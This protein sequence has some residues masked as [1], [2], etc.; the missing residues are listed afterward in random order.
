MID[1]MNAVAADT[2]LPT[3]A[4]AEGHAL[5]VEHLSIYYGARRAVSDV[6]MRIEPRSVTALIGPS[7]CGKSSVL[8]CLNRL[9]EVLPGAHASGRVLL[10][11]QDIYAPGVDPVAVRRRIGM[12]F[13]RPNVFPTMSIQDNVLSGLRL[14]GRHGYQ[15]AEVVERSLRSAALW[16]EVR[17][18]LKAPATALSGGQQQRLCIARA[19]AVQPDVLL[20]DEPC[21][22]LDPVATLKVEELI[23]ALRQ[24]YTIV[25]VTHNMQQATRISDRTAFMNLHADT[26][27]GV[28]VEEGATRDIFSNP[29]MKETEDYVMG[30][31]G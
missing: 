15:A 10:N 25:V 31:F 11:G 6:S 9:H 19:I 2:A 23:L 3:S 27:T 1:S 13:Q 22:A 28:L 4:P 16:D 30:R 12:V 8:R 29:R 21:S 7:G 14:N 26:H 24:D 17:D 18:R 5:Q 20:M